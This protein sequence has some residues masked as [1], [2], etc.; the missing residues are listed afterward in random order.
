M[1][2]YDA[3]ISSNAVKHYCTYVDYG[4]KCNLSRMITHVLFACCR[5]AE[6]CRSLL[7]CQCHA[8]NVINEVQQQTSIQIVR[9]ESAPSC[10][11]VPSLVNF[12]PGGSSGVLKYRRVKKICNTFLVYHLAEHDEIWHRDGHWW[13]DL[14]G[15]WWTLVHF[16]GS[17]YF[18]QK[19]SC[20][21]RDEIWQR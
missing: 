12:G 7:F 16:F 21:E 17:K 11:S 9:R 4:I 15:F 5:S 19:I 6:T 2:C 14:K 13:A 3:V 10:T 20:T 8:F 18:P 1:W